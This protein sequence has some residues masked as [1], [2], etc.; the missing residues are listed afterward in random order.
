MNLLK[1]LKED[2]GISMI[3]ITHDIGL[4]SDLCDKIAVAYAGRACRIR[5]CG[6]GP[7]RTP[8]SLFRLLLASL[9]RLHEI[10]GHCRCRANRRS[11]VDLPPVAAFIPAARC[12][13]DPCATEMPP[14]IQLPAADSPAAG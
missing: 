7:G 5:P 14:E 12:R 10:S 3:F 4:A 2:P 11:L 9:P 8:A 1:D 6:A 13:F